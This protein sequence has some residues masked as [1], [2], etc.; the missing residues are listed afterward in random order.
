[1]AC[2][3]WDTYW[4]SC[5]STRGINSNLFKIPTVQTF[6]A[7]VD[8][9]FN[10]IGDKAVL[11]V[12][13]GNGTTSILMALKGAK[14]IGFD[15]NPL[16]IRYCYENLKIVKENIDI[17]F[18]VWD[19]QEKLPIGQRTVDF[20]LCNQV[21]EHI[22][23]Y[24]KAL[25]EMVRLLKCDGKILITTPN[26]ITHKIIHEHHSHSFSRDGLKKI[27][28]RRKDIRIDK[29]ILHNKVL[30]LNIKFLFKL[31][32]L[33]HRLLQMKKF[34]TMETAYLF[35]IKPLVV[36]YNS[37]VYPSVLNSYLRNE[38]DIDDNTG[39]TIYLIIKKIAKVEA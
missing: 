32:N 23:D 29:I 36:F 38:K 3:L 21:I 10:S 19:A 18:F 20:I 37:V 1:M 13:C 2:S 22:P 27:I 6:L 8:K 7:E 30:S 34:Y 9:T 24:E 25:D 16:A 26:S 39:L 5:L 11:D 17:K 14:V 15:I 35:I 4:N 28:E 33:F 12:G 31:I